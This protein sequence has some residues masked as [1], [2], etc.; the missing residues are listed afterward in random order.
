MN[1]KNDFIKRDFASKDWNL[2]ATGVESQQDLREIDGHRIWTYT[3][4][5][6]EDVESERAN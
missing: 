5:K 6:Y 1:H 2:R 3:I 4:E